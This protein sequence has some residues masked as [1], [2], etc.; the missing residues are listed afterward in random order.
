MFLCSTAESMPCCTAEARLFSAAEAKQT[1]ASAPDFMDINF[2][3]RY[4]AL[5][6]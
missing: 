5:G 6:M 2:I 3:T 4:E 1:D